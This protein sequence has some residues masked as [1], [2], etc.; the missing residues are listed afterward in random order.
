MALWGARVFLHDDGLAHPLQRVGE[1]R[2]ALDT[3]IIIASEVF[4]KRAAAEPAPQGPL[5]LL[6]KATL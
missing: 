2:M 1:R 6:S 3:E 5:P 4:S